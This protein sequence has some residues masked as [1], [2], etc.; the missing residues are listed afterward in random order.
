VAVADVVEAM[1]N[2]RPY[3]PALGI[4]KA[5]DEIKRGRGKQYDSQVV[6]SCVHIFQ[7]GKFS[8]D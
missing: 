4:D 7:E 6:D 1:G 2:H 8:F 3:R 5:L